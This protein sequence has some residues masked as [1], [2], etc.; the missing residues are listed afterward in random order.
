MSG[1]KGFLGRGNRP[2]KAL[3][4]CQKPTRYPA[5]MGRVNKEKKM[6]KAFLLDEYLSYKRK[7]WENST[8]IIAKYH[9]YYT[10][11]AV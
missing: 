7:I 2:Y 11:I 6:Q 4:D 8:Q 5:G 1:E 9:E 10:S 3:N